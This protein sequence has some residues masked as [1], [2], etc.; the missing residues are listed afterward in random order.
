MKKL[1]VFACALCCGIMYSQTDFCASEDVNRQYLLEHPEVAE[2]INAFNRQLSDEIKSGAAYQQR[3]VVNGVYEIPVVVHV[4]HTGGAVGT[5]YNPTDQQINNW[6]NFTNNVFAAT[7]S[8]YTNSEVI[9]VRLVLARRNP[10]CNATNGIVRVNGSTITGY[11]QNGLM[12]NLTGGATQDQIKALT[13]WPADYFYN[14]YIVNTIDNGSSIA[15]FAYYAGSTAA[16]DGAF[17]RASVVSGTNTTLAHEIGHA[18]G[19][20]HVFDGASSSGGQCPVNNDCTLDNDM[21]CDTAPVQS[22]LGIYPSPNNT[23]YNIC[24]QTT[25]NG[26]QYNIMN[27]SATTNRF[28]QGQSERAIAQVVQFRQ[29]LLNSKGT[30]EPGGSQD[31]LQLMQACNPYSAGVLAANY[32]IGPRLVTFGNI[33]NPSGGRLGDGSDYYIDYTSLDCLSYGVSTSILYNANTTLSVSVGINTQN[34]K[35]YVDYNNDGVFNE[36]DELVL[37]QSR[38]A[39]NS[40]TTAD[41]R[42]PANSIR[43]VPLRMR[44]I[45]DFSNFAVNA[46]TAPVYGQ[47]ED[48][49]VTV[50]TVLSENKPSK[51]LAVTAYPN[52]VTDVLTVTSSSA[53]LNLVITDIN[54][55]QVFSNAYSGKE[56]QANLG[57]LAN[58]VYILKVIA[59]GGTSTQKIIKK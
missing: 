59:E 15:G 10:D 44:V 3:T 16:V 6:I 55:R 49:A 58:G 2:E 33:N 51:S 13:R 19:L 11:A 22:L 4:V 14:M 18:I 57:S 25:Y 12:R 35:V 42:P 50:V 5:P 46:C 40:T 17:M 39:A 29:S 53:V 9:P 24:S 45:T 27:Y 21:V 41:V 26:E 48:Y 38:V 43:N 54:G 1:L 31:N 34:M 47:I 32:A 20:K 56:V 52:P 7:A 8:G 30:L 23:A 37:N 28:T 36:T